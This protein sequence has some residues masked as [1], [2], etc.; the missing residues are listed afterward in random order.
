[1]PDRPPVNGEACY[2]QDTVI[3]LV[4]AGGRASRMAGIDKGLVS[5]RGKPLAQWVI[6]ALRPQVSGVIINANRNLNVYAEMA[7][8]VVPDEE[9][10]GAVAYKGP[11]AGMSAGLRAAT[12]LIDSAGGELRWMVTAPCDSP[13]VPTDLVSRLTHAARRNHCKIAVAYDGERI[14]PV[15]SLLALE[16]RESLDEFLL[17][18]GRK[19]DAWFARVGFAE[20]DF[21]DAQSAF[22]NINTEAQRIDVERGLADNR[23]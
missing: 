21:S 20:A 8:T 15:F 5:L 6:E 12:S 2:A 4:L 22:V 17:G 16:L 19:I 3:G 14:Q 23:R 13:F 11:L 10:G 9:S 7:G 18:G 1:M